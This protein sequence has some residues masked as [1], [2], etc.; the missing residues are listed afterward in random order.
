LN[1]FILTFFL[2]KLAKFTAISRHV[3]LASLPDV[4]LVIARALVEEPGVIRNHME[5][6]Q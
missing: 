1:L 2:T 3:S 5:D 4:S 6:A